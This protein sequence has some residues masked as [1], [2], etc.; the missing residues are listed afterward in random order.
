MKWEEDGRREESEVL[1]RAEADKTPNETS[2][3][4]K[5]HPQ[6]Y[7]CTRKRA[8]CIRQRGHCVHDVRP[9]DSKTGFL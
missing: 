3:L 7:G 2:A 4:P 1:T 6:P 5:K 8:G 9:Q